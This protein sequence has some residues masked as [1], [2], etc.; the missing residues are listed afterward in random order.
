[1]ATGR[2]LDD[3]A[4]FIHIS[5]A[6]LWIKNDTLLYDAIRSKNIQGNVW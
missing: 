5:A 3:M 6:Y 1:M 2:I 4:Q